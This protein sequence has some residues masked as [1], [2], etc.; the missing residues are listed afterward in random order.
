MIHIGRYVEGLQHVRIAPDL[1]PLNL[2]SRADYA[3]S[4][5][6]ARDDQT[7]TKEYESVLAVEPD[8][9]FARIM[10]GMTQMCCGD[11]AAALPHFEQAAALA[12]EHPIP[13]FDLAMYLGATGAI[14]EGRRFLEAHVARIGDA[15]YARYNR[16]QAEAY[17][18]NRTGVLICLRHA[19]AANEVILNV[20]PFDPSFDTYRDDPDFDALLKSHGLWP[21]PRSPYLSTA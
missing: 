12:P 11:P 7:A 15:P 21:A 17:L 5:A 1:D 10:I 8:H 14:D 20:L 18:G 16:A 19:V 9:L 13:G 6:Y 2:T 4:C 3:L